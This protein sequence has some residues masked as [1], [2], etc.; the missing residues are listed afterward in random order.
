MAT[1][2]YTCLE[3][4]CGMVTKTPEAFREH[5]KMHAA[6]IAP[7]L[8]A[9]MAFVEAMCYLTA[10]EATGYY[11]ASVLEPKRAEAKDAFV[12]AMNKIAQDGGN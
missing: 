9:I 11:S 10:A 6:A 2:T 7:E 3:R 4:G 1:D 5:Q 12:S 8:Q